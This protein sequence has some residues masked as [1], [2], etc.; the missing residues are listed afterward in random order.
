VRFDD[1]T[2][3]RNVA[4]GGGGRGDPARA[5]AAD[6]RT[7]PERGGFRLRGAFA[8]GPAERVSHQLLP[9]LRE[10]DLQNGVEYGKEEMTATVETVDAGGFAQQCWVFGPVAEGHLQRNRGGRLR[11]WHGIQVEA[12][13]FRKDGPKGENDPGFFYAILNGGFIGWFGNCFC[14]RG[15]PRHPASVRA[16]SSSAGR[17][18]NRSGCPGSDATAVAIVT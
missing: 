12:A 14:L 1:R 13:H 7:D 8:G 18:F 15:H 17:A 16:A 4:D 2:L 11:W 5:Q 6:A 10:S 9:V 3:L